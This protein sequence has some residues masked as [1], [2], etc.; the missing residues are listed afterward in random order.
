MHTVPPCVNSGSGVIA[1]TKCAFFCLCM[2]CPTA[3]YPQAAVTA[4][5]EMSRKNFCLHKVNVTFPQVRRLL[6][7]QEILYPQLF[8]QAVHKHGAEV[9]RLSTGGRDSRVGARTRGGYRC[10]RPAPEGEIRCTRLRLVRELRCP[11]GARYGFRR[12]AAALSVPTDTTGP[13]GYAGWTTGTKA[14]G[15]TRHRR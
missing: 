2:P 3:G 5:D 8:P 12:G 9:H 1:L 7:A 4:V 6:A 10:W 11:A 13:V 14:D 15:P